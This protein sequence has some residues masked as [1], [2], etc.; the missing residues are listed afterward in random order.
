MLAGG[1]IGVFVQ[2]LRGSRRMIDIIIPVALVFT[3]LGLLFQQRE[4]LI[5]VVEEHILAELHGL[6]PLARTEVRARVAEKEVRRS[7][8]K[9]S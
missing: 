4:S 2:I 5:G 1:F 8:F 6:D 9:N 3:G 7:S